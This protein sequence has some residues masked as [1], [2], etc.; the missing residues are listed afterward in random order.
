LERGKKLNLEGRG[1]GEKEQTRK[2][3]RKK[4][5]IFLEER[6]RKIKRIAKSYPAY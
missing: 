1:G 4:R 6:N 2:P 3:E 5:R